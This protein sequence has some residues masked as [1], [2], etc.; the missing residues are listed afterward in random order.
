M[1]FFIYFKNQK[2]QKKETK[3]LTVKNLYL[4]KKM[5][6]FH[7]SSSVSI[8]LSDFFCSSNCIVS[9]SEI[10]EISTILST[11]M[12][13]MPFFFEVFL[14]IRVVVGLVAPRVDFLPLFPRV[15]LRPLLFS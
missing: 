8:K 6:F 4:I 3:F 14:R 9:S 12:S 5:F 10:S 13:I 1:F 7:K 15:F 2:N 11:A